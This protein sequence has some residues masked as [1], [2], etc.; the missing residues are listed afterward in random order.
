MYCMGRLDVSTQVGNYCA[1]A[2]AQHVSKTH[3]Q[4]TSCRAV[5]LLKLEPTEL[6][7]ANVVEAHGL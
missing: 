7:A 1:H 6:L 5:S 2:Q 3:E 4:K